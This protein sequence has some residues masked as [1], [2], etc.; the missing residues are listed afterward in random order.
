MFGSNYAEATSKTLQIE[1][2][3]SKTMEKFLQFLYTNNTNPDCQLLLL[4][5]RYQV[6][7]LVNY[8]ISNIA[9]KVSDENAMEVFYTAFLISNEALMYIASSYIQIGKMKKSSFWED[10]ENKNPKTAEKV[11]N[12]IIGK[13]GN[14]VVPVKDWH[15]SVNPDLR[16]HLVTKLV[17]ASPVYHAMQDK[18]MHKLVTYAR[19]VEGDMYGK[20]N[21]R[22]EYYHLLAKKIY[23]IQKELEDKREECIRQAADANG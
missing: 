13:I 8:C 14:S 1:G 18:R 7:P 15:A 20:A 19:K 23:K 17:S 11:M 6:V 5:D 21:S 2:T 9:M 10:L 4:A 12:L 22:S 16:N 3:D